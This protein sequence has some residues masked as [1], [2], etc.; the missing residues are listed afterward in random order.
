VVEV[1]ASGRDTFALDGHGR[2]WVE[3]RG[4]QL[5]VIN[6]RAL[7]ALDAPAVQ[8]SS[9]VVVHVGTRSFGVL[10]DH[11]LGQHQTVIKPLGRLLGSMRGI[12]GSSILGTGEVALIFDVTALGQ[13]AA[14]LPSHSTRR[15]A[16]R[17]DPAVPLTLEGDR[18]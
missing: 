2:G 3:L 13:L 12:S 8:T 14:A 4:R 5:P 16:T 18:S 9:I 1:I 6:L 10:V 7:Y 15:R 17:T 11:L